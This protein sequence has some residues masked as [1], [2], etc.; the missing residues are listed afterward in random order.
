MIRQATEKD[1]A[2]IATVH[3]TSWKETYTGLLPADYIA[4]FDY[5]KRLQLWESILKKDHHVFIYEIDRQVVGFV[6]GGKIRE[7][8]PSYTGEIY[9]L[10]LLKKYHHCGIGRKLFEHIRQTLSSNFLHPFT[11]WVLASNPA[12]IFYQ[13][14]GGE[15]IDQRFEKIGALEVKDLQL[16][17]C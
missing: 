12:L 4:S 15:I 14:T 5:D 11:A 7:E 13:K 6:A 9:S 16:G 10:Y 1:A 3:V 17:W 8:K 2:D